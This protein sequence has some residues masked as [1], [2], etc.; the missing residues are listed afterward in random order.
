[1]LNSLYVHVHKIFIRGR[2]F[3]PSTLSY[4]ISAE[5]LIYDQRKLFT[6][7]QAT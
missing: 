1:M 4:L 2:S 5:A 6:Y 7:N 3:S